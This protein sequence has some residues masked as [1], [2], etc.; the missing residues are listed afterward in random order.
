MLKSAFLIVIGIAVAVP[1]AAQT[2]V[3]PQPVPAPTAK[4]DVNKLVCKKEETIGSRLAAKK[5]CLTVQQ[6]QE[7]QAED[8]DQMERVQQGVKGPSSGD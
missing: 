2:T 8:R 3:D 5:V 1:A 6:W 7:R 4:S